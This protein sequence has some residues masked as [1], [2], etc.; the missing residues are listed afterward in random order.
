MSANVKRGPQS[1]TSRLGLTLVG[2]LLMIGSPY[3]VEMSGLA[4]RLERT[5]VAAIELV[6]L[7]VGFV[8]LYLSFKRQNSSS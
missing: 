2:A 4:A 5:L 6:A 1:V 7:A 8:C 3:V